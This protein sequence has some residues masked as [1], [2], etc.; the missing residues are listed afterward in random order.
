[1]GCWRCYGITPAMR[2]AGG[3]RAGGDGKLHCGF[4]SEPGRKK[5]NKRGLLILGLVLSLA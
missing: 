4:L 2:F 1:M 5:E 3:G